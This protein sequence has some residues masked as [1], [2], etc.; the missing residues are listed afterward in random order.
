MVYVARSGGD[1]NR[2]TDL[3]ISLVLDEIGKSS[4]ILIDSFFFFFLQYSTKPEAIQT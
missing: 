4:F 2:Y 3:R 1:V